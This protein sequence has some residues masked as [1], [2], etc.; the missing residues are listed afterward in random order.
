MIKKSAF[1][2]NQF[3]FRR[4]FMNIKQKFIRLIPLFLCT[5]MAASH[6]SA[7]EVT[8]II[9]S[10]LKYE[11]IAGQE[12]YRVV[13]IAPKKLPSE[14]L[15]IVIPNKHKGFP[16]IEIGDSAFQDVSYVNSVIIPNSVISIGENAFKNCE[17]LTAI[18]I[19][20]SITRIGQHA[21]ENCDGLTSIALPDS[22]THIYNS[23]FIYCDNLTSVMMGNSVTS[24]GTHAFWGCSSLTD[25]SLPSSLSFI[26]R[27]I[28]Q[29]C[30]SLAYHEQ[31]GL[32]YLGNSNNPTLY[33]A[34][35]APSTTEIIIDGNCKFIADFAFHDN[36][37]ILHAQIPDSVA[38]IGAGA[39]WNCDELE[40]TVKD[41][42]QYIGNEK[43]PY[44]YLVNSEKIVPDQIYVAET[45]KFIGTT[46]FKY[47]YNV[48]H[49][50]IPAS[51]EQIQIETFSECLGLAS[52]EVDENNP[53]FQSI[54]GNLYSKD[55]ATLLRYTP[56]NPADSFVVPDFVNKIGE[57]AFYKCNNLRNVT[58]PNSVTKIGNSAFSQCTNL[59][60][61]EIPDSITVIEEFS[62]FACDELAS[63][64]LPN[65]VTRIEKS[66]FSYCDKLTELQLGNSLE[67]IGLTAFVFCKNLP[68]VTIPNSV[69]TICEAAFGACLSLTE[70]LFNGTI[71]EWNK[72]EKGYQW[73][74]NIPT[75]K[76]LCY[77][78][79]NIQQTEK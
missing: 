30:D 8:I 15:D 9:N 77:T 53:Y 21:F 67:Y 61:I 5:I 52:I 7:C 23:T 48:S 13:D 60:R 38:Y 58:I 35:S 36:D 16:V 40:H 71:D 3:S 50:S 24:I 18:T 4:Y 27:E 34:G 19:P 66:A 79:A 2:A 76:I 44:L 1:N 69:T 56:S 43:N 55:S 6:F 72:I 31:D 65:T 54:D 45:C 11:Q 42:L 14:K 17:G 64:I 51:V 63:V 46:I 29:Y 37:T 26:G 10:P 20:D 68:R 62:F 12:A 39:F 49:I 59:I 22:I 28:F 74:H 78:E 32:L 25:I 57:Y 41:G 70:I 75:T 47:Q 33:L 73:N